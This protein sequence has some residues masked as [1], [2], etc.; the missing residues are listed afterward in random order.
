MTV[1]STRIAIWVEVLTDCSSLKTVSKIPISRG[2][3]VEGEM[4]SIAIAGKPKAD[5]KRSSL[6][7]FPSSRAQGLNS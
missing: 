4:V 5:L 6:V 2:P 7:E 1:A 3:E